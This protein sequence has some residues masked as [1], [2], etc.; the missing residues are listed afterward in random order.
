MGIRRGEMGSRRGDQA[1]HSRG[2][3]LLRVLRG[4]RFGVVQDARRHRRPPGPSGR[5]GNRAVPRGPRLRYPP[6]RRRPQPSGRDRRRGRADLGEAQPN[7]E[8]VTG[9]PPGLPTAAELIALVL[10]HG[11]AAL[12]AYSPAIDEDTD[13]AGAAAWLGIERASIWRE[14]HRRRPDAPP[15]WP[16]PDYPAS[17][18]GSWRYRTLVLHRA[19]MPGRGSAGRG[20]PA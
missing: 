18:G 5:R 1:G 11:P 13:T 16:K 2:R 10:E 20:R 15:R 7:G 6:P 12:D 19:S 9:S 3:L 14:S 17:R 4:K 8:A